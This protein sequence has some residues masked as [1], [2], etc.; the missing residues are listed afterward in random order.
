MPSL[1]KIF[2][3]GNLIRDP[4]M[5]YG[6]QGVPKSEMR[7]AIN[8]SFRDGKTGKSEKRI[9]Y[10]DII[11]WDKP[12]AFCGEHLHRGA[13]ILIEG[14]LQFEERDNRDGTKWTK[15][16]VR[17]DRITNLV[18]DRRSFPHEGG[19]GSGPGRPSGPSNEPREP[20]EPRESRGRPNESRG[21][22][23]DSSRP[24][25]NDPR[26]YGNSRYDASMPLPRR[27]YQPPNLTATP[28]DP[29]IIDDDSQPQF[30]DDQQPN[31]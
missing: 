13:S 28:T 7:L 31:Y 2:L 16:S 11:A 22:G 29:K 12:A 8:E 20:R 18:P 26:V 10:V 27:S 19:G 23:V 5:S 9:L 4:E 25:G 3:I 15:M 1:N 24:Y 6:A 21:H 17:A 30:D 14:R